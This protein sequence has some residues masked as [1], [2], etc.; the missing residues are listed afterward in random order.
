MRIVIGLLLWSVA[1]STAAAT[2]EVGPN[3]TF[4]RVEEAVAAAAPGDTIEVFPLPDGEPYT[5]VG[6][7][8]DKPGLTIRAAGGP[9][10]ARVTLS[11][12]GFEH[13]GR[14]RTPRAIVQFDPGADGGVLDGFE[15][16]GASNRT[17][18]GAGVRIN[19]A[20]HVV[21][22][23]CDIHHN[24]MGIMS[25]GNGT[26]STAA[27]QVIEHSA[28]HNN[29]DDRLSG[30]NHN[31]YLGGTSVT[32]RFCD[33]HQARTGHNIKSRAH[34]IRVEY[35]YVHGSA[36]R[37]FD[38]VDSADTARP[39]SD[40]ILIGNIIVKAPQHSGNRGV[41]HFGQDGGGERNGTL[42]LIHNTVVTPFISPVVDL[43]SRNARAELIG[44]IIDDGGELRRNQVL[45]AGSRGQ[46]TP[47]AITGTNNWLAPGFAN[48]L[49]QTGM[50][51]ADNTIAEESRRLYLAPE[52]HD[53]RLREPWHDIVGAG[54]AL[55]SIQL[56]AT[57]EGGT[58]QPDLRW[59]YLHP[60]R[61]QPRPFADPPDLG[62]TGVA[63]R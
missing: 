47:S 3:K 26:P 13:S 5:A 57:P 17:D 6:V 32:L 7:L 33:V 22:R 28:I 40:A 16:T 1:A 27:G 61:K 42:Y 18:N 20:N 56:P 43:S 24:D 15:L 9:D 55:R 48:R 50:G 38:L 19:Q 53:F 49:A 45:G 34:F 31:L 62:A 29:G 12:A 2:L 39:G 59:Q 63:R 51:A 58:A 60:L 14:G 10:T 21:I 41:I 30:F 52:Q 23:N 36:N 35:C 54:R 46:A 11:G 8:V 4:A 37:E 25:N 44:N